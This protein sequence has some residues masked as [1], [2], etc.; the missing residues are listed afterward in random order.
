MST[1]RNAL[2]AAICAQPDEDTPRLAFADWC[3]EHG[4][5]ER[6]EF[7]RLQ[8]EAERHAE[9][10]PARMDAEERLSALLER[11]RPAW[12]A[13][14]PDWALD[15]KW[16]PEVRHFR[17]GFLHQVDVK[18]EDLL[19]SSDALFAAAPIRKAE[20]RAI[21]D[22]G[23]ALAS[24]PALGRLAS[25][26]I[27]FAEA[28]VDLPALL[29]SPHIS[30][31]V[32]LGLALHGPPFPNAPFWETL[33][34][35]DDGGART[36]AGCV[37]L[38][39]LKAL[40][41]PVGTI[42]SDGIGVLAESSHLSSLEKLDIRANPIE[43]DG[44]VRLAHSPLLTRLTELDLYATRIGDRGLR[45]FLD[46]GP[47]R[48]R[49]IHL[50]RHQDCPITD[51]GV[52]AFSDC[53]ALTGLRELDLSLW[54]LNPARVRAIAHSPYLTELRVLDLSSCG[55]DDDIAV[56]LA[57]SP[58]LRNLRFIDLQNNRIDTRGF[59]ALVRSPVFATVTELVLYNNPEIGDAGITALAE[60]E[61]AGQLR[62]ACLVDNGCGIDGLRA[63]ANSPRMSQLR[64]LNVQGASLGDEGGR[65]LCESPHLARLTA[66]YLDGCGIGAD[67]TA[68]L[69]KRFGA[70][71]RI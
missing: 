62:S 44:L 40:N 47:I 9:H 33:P 34:M 15:P 3:D 71:L 24:S 43:D 50:G 6:A 67:M 69:R 30:G 12:I 2:L 28:P 10:T 65:L 37:A 14:V 54:P 27:G 70:A 1:D 38:A 32:S 41:V 39:Q 48:L 16:L 49:G 63:I 26:E 11:N 19:A 31:L 23:V 25:A 8:F 42:G 64:S 45:A 21:R 51:A 4:E 55:I 36:I 17:R 13:G 59:T 7:I 56:E 35:L 68:A 29:A 18:S 46:A 20:I 61:H 57:Q 53:A 52:R 5:P 58:H 60:S 22:G 66:L